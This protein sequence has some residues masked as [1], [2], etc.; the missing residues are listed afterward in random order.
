MLAISEPSP[1]RTHQPRGRDNHPTLAQRPGLVPND[2][3]VVDSVEVE[4]AVGAKI[5]LINV[6]IFV[7]GQKLTKPFGILAPIEI[8][9]NEIPVPVGRSARPFTEVRNELRRSKPSRHREPS[10]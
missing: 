4:N 8:R 2:A 1:L 7:L 6:A 10:A 9:I 5:V 3:G